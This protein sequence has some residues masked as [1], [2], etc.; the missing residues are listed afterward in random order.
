MSAQQMAQLLTAASGADNNAR[1]QAQRMLEQAEKTQTGQYFAALAEL[2][3]NPAAPEQIRCLAGMN[4]KNAVKAE[5]HSLSQMK[6]ARWLALDPQL[7]VGVKAHVL[8]MLRDPSREVAKA[9]SIALAYIGTIELAAVS[10]ASPDGA[11]PEL[12][13]QLHDNVTAVAA[14]A[15]AS[16]DAAKAAHVRQF[17][18]NAMGYLCEQLYEDDVELSAPQ[19]N[20]LLTAIIHCMDMKQPPSVRHA[21][22]K[23]LS[24]SLPFA[25]ANFKN[26]AE[27]NV[28][29]K[30]V[31]ECTTCAGPD[32]DCVQTRRYAFV[33]MTVVAAEYY[34]FLPDYMQVIFQLTVST[35]QT[36]VDPVAHYALEFWNTLCDVEEEINEER[37]YYQQQVASGVPLPSQP[38]ASSNYVRGAVK[39]LVPEVY[40]AMC[41]QQEYDDEGSLAVQASCCMQLCASAVGDDILAHVMPL[42]TGNIRNGDW[43]LREAATYAFGAIMDGCSEGAV[44]K[45]ALEALPILVQMV[46][47]EAHPKTKETAAWTLSRVTEFQFSA[48]PVQLPQGHALFAAFQGRPLDNVIRAALTG[49][50]DPSGGVCHQCCAI[51]ER[52]A[53]SQDTYD[54]APQTNLLS[55][56]FNPVLQTLTKTSGRADHQEHN[57]RMA[58]HEALNLWIENS[59]NDCVQTV[60][61]LLPALLQRLRETL[62]A[63]AAEQTDI[64]PRLL[65]T[66][67]Q[68]ISR[69]GPIAKPQCPTVMQLCLSI[70]ASNSG[71]PV[72]EAECL[73][74]IMAVINVE[75]EDFAKYLPA[76][77]Q[78]MLR[79]VK[80][81]AEVTTCNS[82]ISVMGDATGA[83]GTKMSD[84]YCDVMMNEFVNILRQPTVDKAIKPTVFTAFGTIALSLG[85]RFE[86]YLASIMPMLQQAA[87]V[88]VD[89]ENEEMVEYMTMLRTEIMSSYTCVVQGMKDSGRENGL[90]QYMHG[91][92]QVVMTVASEETDEE[93][94]SP[95]TGLIGDLAQIYGGQIKQALVQGNQQ[96]LLNRVITTCGQSQDPETKDI[97]AFAM[98]QVQA[99]MA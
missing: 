33:C 40:R 6:K 98:Q 70:M 12:C 68:C 84:Q 88:R 3:G 73:L 26:A 8:N 34:S 77:F 10:D 69:M 79:G 58:S 2:L 24:E 64:H 5:E 45:H 89:Q 29:M 72:A 94:L 59:A 96:G 55:T 13:K 67:N 38:R 76:A 91:I 11:W 83:L 60:A 86:K 54:D 47:A 75:N 85:A 50:S 16:G 36:D 21:A 31:C 66:V 22:V 39:H 41:K 78:F 15:E 48:I 32:P 19:T 71:S 30:K 35:L 23:A 42:V 80:N 52:V 18:L 4:I 87:T 82:A 53:K 25:Q 97:A 7:R 99:A 90:M 81:T 93:C 51:L 61:A 92:F 49:L 74:L 27:R 28:I 1:Q 20:K 63:S 65:S 37:E 43:H 14:Q 17:T 95:T 62:Q 56:Y 46:T 44:G 57:L 9:A